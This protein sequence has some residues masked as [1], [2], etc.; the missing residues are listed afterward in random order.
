MAKRE[1]STEE[2]LRSYQLWSLTIFF[3]FLLAFLALAAGL[4]GERLSLSAS[5]V[6]LRALAL[7]S[8]ASGL[9]YIETAPFAI[10]ILLLAL[11]AYLALSAARGKKWAIIASIALLALDLLYA[12]LSFLPSFPYPFS[13]AEGI[14][15]TLLHLLFLSFL[16]V[17]LWKYAKLSRLLDKE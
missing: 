6:F 8:L 17:F 13:L 9:P 14:I 10:G 16:S 11:G 2:A 12:L 1:K 5:F 7:W 15:A 4:W 3:P